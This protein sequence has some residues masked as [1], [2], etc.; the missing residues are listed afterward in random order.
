MLGGSQGALAL[1]EW[2]S[3]NFD[4]LAEKGIDVL[5]VCGPGK[6]AFP[7]RTVK[8]K[9]CGERKIAF[10]EFCDD[11][12]SAMSAADLAVARAGAGTLAELAR[13]LLPSVIVPYPFA[14][15]NHQRENA[16][17]IEKLGGCALQDQND[18]HKLFDEGACLMGYSALLETMRE[19]LA[20]VDALNDTS[21]IIGDLRIVAAG[22]GEK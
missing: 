9:N 2:A 4:R 7:D 19:N 6:N 21:K 14:A 11:M 18:M 12:A 13:C 10:L 20:R 8:T 3:H 5:S 16:N 1:N 22:A 17:C 15:D